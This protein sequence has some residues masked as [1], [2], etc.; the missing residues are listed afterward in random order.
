MVRRIRRDHGRRLG[1][2]YPI[3]K[4]APQK[5]KS[6]PL[7]TL[8]LIYDHV[9]TKHTLLRRALEYITMGGKSRKNIDALKE[10]TLMRATYPP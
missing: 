4:L 3:R 5:K 7:Y 2:V 1:S 9:G 10:G 8:C 6:Y